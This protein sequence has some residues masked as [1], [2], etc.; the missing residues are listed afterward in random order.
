MTRL[1][2]HS[3]KQP[4]LSFS[5]LLAMFVSMVLAGFGVCIF[6]ECNIGSDTLTVL[7]DGVHQ[8]LGTTLGN[9]SRICNITILLLAII[10]N[11]KAVGIETVIYAL[12]IGSFIDFAS[13]IVASFSLGQQS[14]IVRFI[15]IGVAQVFFAFGFAIMIKANSGIH[16]IDA[17]VNGIVARFHVAYPIVRTLVDVFFV[18]SGMILGGVVGIG[19]LIACCSTGILI[20]FFKKMLHC[21]TS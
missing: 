21:G 5:G 15:G 12:L 11:R 16:A 20:T 7:L 17:T 14:W 10:T 1:I 8:A 6:V 3:I 4:Y 2:L 13:P 9:A 19:T 18:I